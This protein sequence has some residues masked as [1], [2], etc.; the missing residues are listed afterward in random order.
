VPSI[1]FVSLAAHALYVT[2]M[3]VLLIW[4]IIKSVLL[5]VAAFWLCVQAQ[6]INNR[7]PPT[8]MRNNSSNTGYMQRGEGG[9]E[10]GIIC[11]LK[12]LS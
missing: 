6:L 3:A 1:C 4:C 7:P 11:S 9:A 2:G 12:H 5:A 10:P 8:A